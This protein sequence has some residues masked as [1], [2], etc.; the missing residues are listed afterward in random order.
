MTK[1]QVDQ[2]LIRELSALLEETGL[3]EIEISEEG[4]SIRISRSATVAAPVAGSTLPAAEDMLA[5]KTPLTEDGVVHAPIVG[6]VYLSPQPDA[7]PFVS[8]GS[9][10]TEGQ[11]LMIIEAMKVMNQIP[12][13]RAGTLE[14]VLVQDGQPVEFGEPLVVLK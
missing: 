11:T 10:V 14:T 6:T 12:A 9:T 5:S 8:P 3:S 4:R 2:D 13:P 7:A 1:L